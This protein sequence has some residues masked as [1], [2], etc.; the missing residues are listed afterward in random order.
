MK[1]IVKVD[2]D[3]PPL[4]AS[5]ASYGLSLAALIAEDPG[6]N[7]APRHTYRWGSFLASVALHI[8][9]ITAIVASG[10]LFPDLSDEAALAEALEESERERPRMIVLD[11]SSPFL[12]PALEESDDAG[13][14][15]RDP[16]TTPAV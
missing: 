6:L 8:A 4:A 12:A 9:V 13:E 16:K 15:S 2:P 5:V 3:A 11:L 10:Q 7:T 14:T 1:L